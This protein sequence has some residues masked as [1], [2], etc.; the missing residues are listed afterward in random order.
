MEKI[1][2][3][4]SQSMPIWDRQKNRL[5]H[6]SAVQ[7]ALL[8]HRERVSEREARTQDRLTQLQDVSQSQYVNAPQSY[9]ISDNIENQPVAASEV[10]NTEVTESQSFNPRQMDSFYDDSQM[11]SSTDKAILV[12]NKEVANPEEGP[13]DD[14]PKGSYVD[15]TV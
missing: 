8:A 15:Y 1:S 11:G 14:V 12:V 9:E 10:T 5:G 6:R 2:S 4:Q 7:G 13:V 3:S